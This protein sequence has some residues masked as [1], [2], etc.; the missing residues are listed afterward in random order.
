VPGS[1]TDQVGDVAGPEELLAAGGHVA[2]VLV[3]A[4]AGAGPE[5][6]GD[7]WLGPQRA[8]RQHER[9][10]RVHAAVRVGQRERLLLGHRVAVRCGIVLDVTAGR[11]AAQPLGHIPR[12]GAV[13]LASSP[14]VAGATAS[15]WYRP[16]LCPIRTLAGGDRR[17]EIAD[18]LTE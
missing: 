17:A 8:E 11:L 12:A 6:L 7:P 18:E 15:A 3:P 14:A 9:A 4:H 5:R 10:R 13:R 2:V 16:R 1:R